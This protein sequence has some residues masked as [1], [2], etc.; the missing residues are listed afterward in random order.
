MIKDYLVEKGKLV[1][2]TNWGI[3]I[4]ADKG[5]NVHQLYGYYFPTT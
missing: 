1:V 2:H 3:V 4:Y 5:G